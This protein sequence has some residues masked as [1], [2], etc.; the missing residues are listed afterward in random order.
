V[1]SQSVASSV[2]V[3]TRSKISL[4]KLEVLEVGGLVEGEMVG[5]GEGNDATDG[6]GI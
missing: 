4:E 6:P 2:R 5:G 3:D 1:S